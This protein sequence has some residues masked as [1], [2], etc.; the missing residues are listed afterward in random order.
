VPVL[1]IAVFEIYPGKE[2]ECLE[3]LSQLKALMARRGY[4]RDTLF[5]DT[6]AERQYILLRLWASPEARVQAQ[7]DP[8][9]HRI[10]ARLPELSTV[11]TVYEVLEEVSY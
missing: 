6:N 1:S 9:A 10:W 2:A 5:S 4:A 7:E 11:K 8:E 3:A